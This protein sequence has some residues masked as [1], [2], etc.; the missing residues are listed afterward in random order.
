MIKYVKKLS[1]QSDFFLH[2][3]CYVKASFLFQLQFMSAS[4]HLT[5]VLDIQDRRT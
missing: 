4:E 2:P 5:R 3:S 1:G